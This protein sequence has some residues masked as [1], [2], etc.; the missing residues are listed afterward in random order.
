MSVGGAAPSRPQ[1]QPKQLRSGDRERLVLGDLDLH[2]SEVINGQHVLAQI[3]LSAAAKKP[4]ETSEV[5]DNVFLDV[6]DKSLLDSAKKRENPVP[7]QNQNVIV[8]PSKAQAPTRATVIVAQH[9]PQGPGPSPG[10]P[11]VRAPKAAT[12]NI[13]FE[14]SQTTEQ[15]PKTQ[16]NSEPSDAENDFFEE[17]FFSIEQIDKLD[18]LAPHAGEHCISLCSEEDTWNKVPKLSQLS[19]D[20]L[21]NSNDSFSGSDQS[22]VMSL[23]SSGSGD[24]NIFI[25]PA[26]GEGEGTK[27][28]RIQD[29]G[30][31]A[32]HQPGAWGDIFISISDRFDLDTRSE[33]ELTWMRGHERPCKRGE[34]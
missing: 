20:D 10:I 16:S 34:S 19:F 23:C 32:D 17:L 7:S 22:S 4:V 26:R 25:N 29:P 30:P 21:F 12:A 3:Q 33:P 14:A 9:L 31:W 13:L 28:P 24:Q 15:G 8:H 11:T 5:V 27:K 1:S 6:P 18:H 2:F